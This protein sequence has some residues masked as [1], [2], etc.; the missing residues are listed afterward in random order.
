MDIKKLWNNGTEDQWKE[1]LELYENAESVKRNSK[2]E[3][4]LNRVHDNLDLIKAMNAEGFYVF[5]HDEYFVWKYTARNRYAS[6]TKVLEKWYST[7]EGKTQLGQIKDAIFALQENENTQNDIELQLLNVIRIK[8]L[9]VAGASGL[10]AILFPEKFGTLDQFV[11]KGLV[12]IGE[13][14]NTELDDIN[15]ESIDIKYSALLEKI[16]QKKAK[17]LNEKFKTTDWT[18]RKIDMVLWANRSDN[19]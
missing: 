4:K 5:L 18:P 3:N 15:P 12:D 14:V 10:L 19:W 11:V 13:Y 1:A 16:L 17:K 2:L 6:T 9:G 7:E 8:G